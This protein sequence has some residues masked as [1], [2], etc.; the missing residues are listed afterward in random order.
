MNNAGYKSVVIFDW[1]DTLYPTSAT[2]KMQ[3]THQNLNTLDNLISELFM[4]CLKTSIV[5][6]ITNATKTWIEHTLNGLPKTKQISKYIKIISARDDWIAQT[7]NIF[8]WKIYS[9]KQEYSSLKE[10][11]AN[12]NILSFG[13]AEYEYNALINLYDVSHKDILKSIKFKDKP[14]YNELCDELIV[15]NKIINKIIDINKHLDWHFN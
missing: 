8:L 2:Y 5:I 9:F 11:N 10:N 4:Q 15:V 13:D 6:I 3:M 14:N 1:D 12:L 7:N